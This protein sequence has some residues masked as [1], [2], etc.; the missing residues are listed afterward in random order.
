MNPRPENLTCAGGLAPVTNYESHEFGAR[1]RTRT[2]TPLRELA[3]EASA[4]ANSAIRAHEQVK[5]GDFI[6]PA[7]R[8]VCQRERSAKK[9]EQNGVALTTVPFRNT[10]STGGKIDVHFTAPREA[11]VVYSAALL[12]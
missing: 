10:S 4:S 8:R 12:C 1:K 2:S 11:A 5:R 6:V 3:P 7:R 9:A